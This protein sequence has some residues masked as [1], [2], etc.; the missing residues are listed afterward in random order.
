[1]LNTNIWENVYYFIVVASDPCDP[2]Q[3]RIRLIN[4]NSPTE[5]RLEVCVNGEW[6]TVCDDGF[7]LDEGR[8]ACSKQLGLSG[9]LCLTITLATIYT[10]RLVELY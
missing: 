9:K 2:N 4:G 1:M 8:V 6:G 3:D 10:C 5:G 7:G